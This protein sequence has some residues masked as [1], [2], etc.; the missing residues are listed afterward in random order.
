MGAIRR[1]LLDPEYE[2]L[3]RVRE[4]PTLREDGTPSRR[5]KAWI[6]E[7]VDGV[8]VCRLEVHRTEH[9]GRLSEIELEALYELALQTSP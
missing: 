1:E 9:L 3:I 6:F 5:V 2:T 7:N 4:A 8:E